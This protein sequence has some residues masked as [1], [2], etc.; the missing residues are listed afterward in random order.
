MQVVVTGGA[1]MLGKKLVRAIL[2]KGTLAGKD[3]QQVKVERIQVLDVVP[4][5]NLTSA[6]L[7]NDPRV[8]YTQ[9]EV[10]DAALMKTLIAPGTGSVFHF[11]AVVSAGAEA[12][13]DLGYRVN[14]D[15]TRVVLDACRALGS[16]PRVVFT[17]S[18][19]VYGGEMPAV[20]PDDFPLRPQTS[21]GS[22]KA[23]GELLLN[24]YTRKGFIDGRA[25]RLPTIVVRPG[26][27]NLA[28]STFASSIIREPLS[29]QEAVCP[30]DPKTMM[31][32]LSPRKTIEAFLRAHELPG[33]T[34]GWNRALH[35]PSLDVS[36]NEMA[37]GLRKVAG[38]DAYKR[39]KW[40]VE[41]RIQAIVAT[42]PGRLDSKRA[43]AM[44]FESDASVE[45]I[46]NAFIEDDLR[47]N[48]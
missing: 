38:A 9:G 27:P 48:A 25:L 41:P 7:P 30:V 5:G 44:G 40:Q 15:G 16:S 1:G 4:P 6:D 20:I 37:E 3:G 2:K 10:Y 24:D 19:A 11:A 29:G 26:K 47:P 14:L 22:Q 46:I 35:L 31:P 8:S 13:T 39:I 33:S 12:D 17:S 45:A 28:A 43:R 32:L 36:V 42:W 18:V 23:M 34:W 21:Y